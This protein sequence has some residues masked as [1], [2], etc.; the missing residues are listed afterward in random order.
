MIFAYDL[1]KCVAEDF[2]FY[3]DNLNQ[4]DLDEIDADMVSR[5]VNSIKSTQNSTELLMLFAYFYFINGRF[6]TTNEHTFVPRADLPSEVNGETLNIKKLYDK[7]RRTD[8][9]GIV[10]SQF[11]AALNIFFSGDGEEISRNFV[12]EFY[13]NMTVSALSTDNSFKFDAFTDLLTSLSLMF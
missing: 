7:F 6:P 4:S 13:Q 1:Y 9:H 3:I 5:G 8:S 2:K 10:S 12:S 11:L